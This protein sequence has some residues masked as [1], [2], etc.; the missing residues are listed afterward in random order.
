M[1]SSEDPVVASY[2]VLLTDSE[3]SR[4]VLQYL[5]R[6][7]K[8]PYDESHKQK[9]TALRMKPKTG[10]VEVDIPID[11]RI[12]YDVTKGLKYGDAMKKSRTAREG[13]GHGMAGGFSTG[14]SAPA[15]NRVKMEGNGDVEMGGMDSK[16]D[17]A[18]LLRV[19]TL[20]GRVKTAEEGD[21]VYM[22]AAFRGKNLHLSPVSAVVQLQPQLHHLDALEEIPSK[23]RGK[24][25]NEGNEEKSAEAEGRTIDVKIKAAE[26]GEQAMV[27]GNL[28]LLKQMQDEK[29]NSYDWV[30]AE[31]YEAYQ[32]YEDYMIHQN[33]DDLPQLESAIESEDYLDKMSAPRIDPARPEMTGWAMKQ[34][35]KKQGE[36]ETPESGTE[37]G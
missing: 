2:D 6:D 27:A 36:G 33:I 13:G 5:D 10:L 26:D 32:T 35:R 23:A 19:Q 11:P 17:T 3:I 16:G 34:N 7:P 29:W 15:G 30:D 20:G 28:E 22:L 37:E 4:F 8:N 31:D 9:P 1:D 14:A 18:S 12:N 21:P 25:R 24:A